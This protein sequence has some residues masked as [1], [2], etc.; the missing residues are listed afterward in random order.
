MKIKQVIFL[1]VLFSCCIT[2]LTNCTKKTGCNADSKTDSSCV[3]T[4]GG[5]VSVA[6]ITSFSFNNTSGLIAGKNI[7]VNM[8]YNTDS[9]NL[10]A[11][12]ATSPS[13]AI[14][15]IGTQTQISGVTK[16]DFSHGP[17]T[18]TVTTADGIKTLNYIV[19][20]NNA[21]NP[22]KTMSSYSIL[23]NDGTTSISGQISGQNITVT[24]PSNTTNISQLVASF[25]TNPINIAVTVGTQKQQSGIT[26]N[27][28]SK[29]K[30]LITYTVTA[31][32]GSKA[33][34]QVT[35]IVPKS[36]DAK[37]LGYSINGAASPAIASLSDQ[38][39]NNITM[40]PDTTSV[41]NLIATFSYIG[42][43]I[44]VTVGGVTTNQES[45]T[46]Q[47]DFT[48]DVTYVVTSA[49]SSIT[50]SYKIHVSIAKNTDTEISGYTLHG[51]LSDPITLLSNQQVNNVTMPSGTS[52]QNLIATF[53]YVGSK[54]TVTVGGVITN[55][56][57]GTTPNNF[58]NDVTYIVTAAD[59]TTTKNYTIHVIVSAPPTQSVSAIVS[60]NNNPVSS[61]EAE[62][63]QGTIVP[64]AIAFNATIPSQKITVITT[65]S[66][67]N[68]TSTT[69]NCVTDTTTGTCTIS[70][71]YKANVPLSKQNLPLTYIY[72]GNTNPI[73]INFKITVDT[74]DNNKTA[75]NHGS[76]NTLTWKDSQ[77][78]LINSNEKKSVSS[79]I[80]S[81]LTSYSLASHTTQ[82]YLS[83]HGQ[84]N[85]NSYS[86]PL[87]YNNQVI[88]KSISFSGTSIPTGSFY[89]YTGIDTT[90][91]NYYR[92]AELSDG[93]TPFYNG[94]KTAPIY[95]FDNAAGDTSLNYYIVTIGHSYK[96]PS[97]PSLL[98]PF[99]MRISG[100]SGYP[101][102][103]SAFHEL[104]P[105]N[106]NQGTEIT[107]ASTPLIKVGSKIF[108]KI[109]YNL[110]ASS[111]TV[112]SP[113]IYIFDTAMSG[114]NKIMSISIGSTRSNLVTDN[115]HI[116][117]GDDTGEIHAYDLSGNEMLNNKFNSISSPIAELIT[118]TDNNTIYA[119]TDKGVYSFDI[120]NFDST[121]IIS[122]HKNFL[123]PTKN[124]LS[125][126]FDMS[127]G[128]NSQGILYA[129]NGNVVYAINANDVSKELWDSSFFSGLSGNITAITSDNQGRVYIGDEGS[130]YSFPSDFIK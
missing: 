93:G 100:A 125:S 65:S 33:N 16:N 115:K 78:L 121:P 36:T 71:I 32:D 68:L 42:S 48:N 45:G 130:I 107:D 26:T 64:L 70:L 15:T 103:A 4:G 105:F 82:D 89:S 117:V 72:T 53:N 85:N 88:Y 98:A 39:I 111:D 31:A 21:L 113:K 60:V 57:S 34:Y 51:A 28:F 10:I 7:T 69:S 63:Q 52:V 106:G 17:I 67:S 87:V 99:I 19:T 128:L 73:S 126:S 37:I 108:F 74:W 20:V 119:L 14:V 27:D 76:I 97:T 96:T 58:A 47:N 43:K 25:T 3:N 80:K 18:Y 66:D 56:E 22:A 5:N 40:P 13:S 2:F 50:K 104:A 118:S 29:T 94:I 110:L 122:V 114:T 23:A 91:L 86:N 54:I 127:L 59:G 101:N 61:F 46:T 1:F 30:G 11:S 123:F 116:F 120:T 44:T 124:T 129:A 112:P 79:L 75:I 83:A 35:V 24:M 38:Q 8:P 41:K 6:A 95:A 81:Y 62:A 55:Q 109:N 49:D 92:K 77:N 102:P 12:F 9:R 90:Y 84:V